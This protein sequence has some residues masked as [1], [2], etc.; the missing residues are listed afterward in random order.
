MNQPT[1]NDIASLLLSKHS[2]DLCIPQCKTGGTYVGAY[3]IMDLWVIKK[4]FTN[5]ISYAYEIKVDRQDF[6]RDTKWKKYLKYCNEF[7]FVAPPGLIE[8]NELAPEAGL[9]VTS[10]NVK[11]L[12]MK[13][14]AATRDI[15]I[16][17]S[18]FLYVL[19]WRSAVHGEKRSE[20][21]TAYWRSWLD[22][23]DAKLELGMAVSNRIMKIVQKLE[24]ENSKLQK[25]EYQYGNIKQA[26]L[27]AGYEEADIYSWAFPRRFREDLDGKKQIPSGI[28]NNANIIKRSADRIQDEIKT[29]KESGEAES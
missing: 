6:L 10:K 20:D 4:S 29:F 7:Y 27:E 17:Q 2:K 9:L 26:L 24:R 15:E 22:N 25:V 19:F 16:P 28:I 14:K 8:P 23:K 1:E 13:K 21:N 5:P 11:L 18:L 3:Q 12:Y